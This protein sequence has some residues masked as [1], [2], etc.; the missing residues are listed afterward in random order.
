MNE[1]SLK[2]R[3]KE[4][5]T[6]AKDWVVANRGYVCFVVGA[7]AMAIADTAYKNYCDEKYKPVRHKDRIGWNEL[8]DGDPNEYVIEH[9]LYDK[10]GSYLKT[11]RVGYEKSAWLGAIKRMQESVTERDEWLAKQNKTTDGEEE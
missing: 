1:K 5:A 9:N 3:A 2:E 4:K 11:T 8:P 7:T 6:K 10:D